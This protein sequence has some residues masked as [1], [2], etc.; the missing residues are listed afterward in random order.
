MCVLN[1]RQMMYMFHQQQTVILSSEQSQY[2]NRQRLHHL[3]LRH[4]L[5]FLLSMV[6][7]QYHRL[8]LYFQFHLRLR[9]PL[10]RLGLPSTPACST[11]PT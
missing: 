5:Q 1:I 6:N 11:R 4:D 3:H 10:R 7:Y 8:R 2:L 9:L